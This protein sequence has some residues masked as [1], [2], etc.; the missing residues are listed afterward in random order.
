MK[1][2]GD[3]FDRIY[4]RDT[5]SSALW[6]TTRHKRRSREAN[7]FIQY[8]D[9]RLADISE[10]I[11]AGRY[12]F[13]EYRCFSVRDT[14]TRVVHAPCFQDRV[15]HHAIIRVT[16]RVFE[17]SAMTNSYACI[18]GRGQHRALQ[19]LRQWT[20]RH[21][22]YGKVDV[23]KFYDSVNHSML[24]QL[25]ARRFREQRL[26]ALFD[27]LIQSWCHKPGYGIPI[28]ALTSQWFGNFYLDEV[29]RALLASSVV[30]YYQR[31]MDDMLLLGTQQ[32]VTEARPIVM[33]ALEQLELVAKNNG[34]WNRAAQGIPWLG[35]T[36]YP[37]RVRL[38]SNGRRRLR[39]KF[40]SLQQQFCA[41]TLD[42]YGYQAR[43]SALFAHAQHAT[44]TKWRLGLL[45]NNDNDG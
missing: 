32:Q 24:M 15:V 36:I 30:P 6:A 33:T 2:V 42:E 12:Q 41:G 39:R 44:D 9:A 25:L 17:Q 20:R 10:S 29:D 26:L 21:H 5:L 1:R 31:Y 23:R 8:A 11:R 28:G 38:N 34:E 13:S 40:K 16:G 35:F 19:Q 4:Q 37:D 7:E 22:W 45:A 14:K 27:T 43:A 3:L 18:S